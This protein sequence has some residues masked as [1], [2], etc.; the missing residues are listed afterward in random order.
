MSTETTPAP[1]DSFLCSLGT[2]L[3]YGEAGDIYRIQTPNG[4][5]IGIR[6]NTAPSPANVEADISNRAPA[7]SAP[8]SQSARVVLAR[9]TPAEKA[10]LRACSVPGIQDAYD[11]ALIEGRISEADPDFPAFRAGLDA[12]GIIAAA[13][14]P[15]LLAP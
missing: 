10:A 9:L 1:F 5:V 3:D 13:R 8:L 7:P 15:A 14:W 12:L 6:A 2:V 4:Q 11:V